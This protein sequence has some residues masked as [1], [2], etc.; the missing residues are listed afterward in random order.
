[1]DDGS[2]SESGTS[3][4]DTGSTGEDGASE[5]EDEDSGGDGDGESPRGFEL[6]HP[7]PLGRVSVITNAM[8]VGAFTKI[9]HVV[10][11]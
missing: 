9:A 10:T 3:T 11:S 5:G 4:G 1:M 7:S 6:V 2:T 8:T